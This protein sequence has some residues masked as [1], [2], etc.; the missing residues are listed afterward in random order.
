MVTQ[1]ELE[2]KLRSIEPLIDKCPFCGGRTD[3]SGV[4]SLID[5]GINK[6][7]IDIYCVHHCYK[8]TMNTGVK[9]L[10]ELDSWL[11]TLIRFA[12]QRN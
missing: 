12:N 9:T 10:P 2:L 7:F 6:I 5:N 8:R 3:V 11:K 4:T 1:N